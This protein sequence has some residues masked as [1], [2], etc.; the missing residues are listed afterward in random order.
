M[1]RITIIT[2]CAA[3]GAALLAG[4]STPDESGALNALNGDR[5]AGGLAPLGG[6]G[7]LV[8][9]AQRWARHL[10]DA[11]GGQCSMETLVHSHLPDEAPPGW[12]RLGENVGCRIAPGDVASFVGPLQQAFMNSPK[13]RDNIM[14]GEYNV[15]GV[16]LATAP[17]AV[18]NGWIVVYEAQ[19]FARL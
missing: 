6:N 8:G 15:A 17:A 11:S 16:G 12:R 1:K 13:H 7:P 9:K 19:E 3:L 18:G 2:I 4:C 14:H 5:A 10:A